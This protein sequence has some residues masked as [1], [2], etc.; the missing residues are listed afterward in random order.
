MYTPPAFA[1]TDRTALHAFIA[2]HP[3]ALLTTADPAGGPP[4]VTPL[5]LIAATEEGE[6]GTLYGHLAKPNPHGAALFAAPSRVIF[7]GPDAYV[8][9]GW[10]P[11]KRE[12]GK[13]VPTW[14]YQS[15]D[16]TGTAEP[17][18]D[19]AAIHALLTRLTDRFE[20]GRA[21]RWRIS[22]APEAYIAA[23]MRG[24]T[25][26]RLPIATLVGK[27]KLSQNRPADDIAGVI[28]G[29]KAEADAK[30]GALALSML[31]TGAP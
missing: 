11:S 8:S 2:A 27:W 18:A 30:A 1:E 10:Y 17:I 24:I 9:P 31:D 25:A 7:Q 14:N 15:V 16:V 29:L 12:H 5:P 23:L 22:D 6:N 21:D 28:A 4:L 3:F 20:S 19:P 13:A 26:F